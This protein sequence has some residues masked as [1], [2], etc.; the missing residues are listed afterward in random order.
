MRQKSYCILENLTLDTHL[1]SETSVS[2]MNH[3]SGPLTLGHVNIETS[4]CSTSR[5][6]LDER[7]ILRHCF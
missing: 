7:R 4:R 1:G 2:M 6:R 3:S 5:R